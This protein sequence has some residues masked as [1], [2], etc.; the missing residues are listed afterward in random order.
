MKTQPV[1]SFMFHR[2][3]F[4]Y[5]FTRFVGLACCYWLHQRK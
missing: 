5:S 1:R 3:A 4:F 2:A